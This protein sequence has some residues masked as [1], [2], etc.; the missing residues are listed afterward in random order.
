[1]ADVG[2]LDQS[3]GN[4]AVYDAIIIPC[5]QKRTVALKGIEH[6][7]ADF[8]KIAKEIEF[9]DDLV[10]SRREEKLQLFLSAWKKSNLSCHAMLFSL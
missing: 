7:D 2:H 4:D 6:G 8:R 1:M 10:L 5:R 9:G 3:V